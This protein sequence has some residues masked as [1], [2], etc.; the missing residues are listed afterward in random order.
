MME[1]DWE[2]DFPDESRECPDG[3]LGCNTPHV[4]EDGPPLAHWLADDPEPLSPT[5]RYPYY[6]GEH[7]I[8]GP[9]VFASS[10]EKVIAWKGVNYY[11]QEEM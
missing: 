5:K 4:F 2:L 10:D 8:L 11:R 7:L 9:E 3:V 6:D 1:N